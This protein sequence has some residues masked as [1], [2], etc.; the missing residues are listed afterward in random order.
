[1]PWRAGAITEMLS[2]QF[3]FMEVYF[4]FIK[5]GVFEVYWR[6]LITKLREILIIVA[7]HKIVS[8]HFLTI[9]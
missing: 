4:L 1:M 3:I 6:T 9:Y 2:R 7:L 5:T 8:S